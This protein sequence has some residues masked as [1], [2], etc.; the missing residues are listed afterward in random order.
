MSR[1]SKMS[2]SV[3]S[4]GVSCS[5]L[6]LADLQL[7]K[8]PCGTNHV[9]PIFSSKEGDV[10]L[11][12]PATFIIH[13]LAAFSLFSRCEHGANPSKL[14]LNKLGAISIPCNTIKSSYTSCRRHLISQ[15]LYKYL[16]TGNSLRMSHLVNQQSSIK[17]WRRGWFTLPKVFFPCVFISNNLGVH[18]DWEQQMTKA[19]LWISILPSN[20]PG[21]IITGESWGRNC[22]QWYYF[23]LH[24]LAD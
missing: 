18:K 24:L 3:I 20:L 2:P 1:R 10:G 8:W 5:E 23:P 4:I 16:F 6:I 19:A 17:P 7:N 14:C 12:H 22:V 21:L 13:F 15:L 11:S 9:I